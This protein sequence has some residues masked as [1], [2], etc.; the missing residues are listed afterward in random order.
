MP[1]I[2][3]KMAKNHDNLIP[4]PTSS[5]QSAGRVQVDGRGRNVWHWNDTQIDS[6]SILLKRLENNELELEPT[7][8][9]PIQKDGDADAHAAS[10]GKASARDPSRRDTAARKPEPRPGKASGRA[11]L[12]YSDTL[13][14]DLGGGG[15]DP[16][17]RS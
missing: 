5:G 7:R 13:S 10:S 3:H 16:Y 9:V 2:L 17:N 12:S 6:T 14:I 4:V 15:F 11:E 8:K 1:A